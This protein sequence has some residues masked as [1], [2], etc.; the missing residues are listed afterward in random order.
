MLNFKAN[1]VVLQPG[2][3]DQCF[4]LYPEESLEQWHKARGLWVD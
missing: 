1:W 2:D 4:D 3:D